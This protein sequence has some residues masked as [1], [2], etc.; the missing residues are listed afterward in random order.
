MLGQK[1]TVVCTQ[2]NTLALAT[3]DGLPAKTDKA[4]LLRKLED[5]TGHENI[6]QLED[7]VNIMDGN[8]LLQAL[9]GLPQTFAELAEKAYCSLPKANTVHF[10]TDTYQEDAIK[11]IE[12]ERWESEAFLMKGQSARLPPERRA[13]RQNNVNK[14]SLNLL[15]HTELKNRSYAKRLQ[16]CEVLFV[17]KDLCVCLSSSDGLAVQCSDVYELC[18]PQEEADTRIILHCL[19]V[20]EHDTTLDII[21][22]SSNTDVIILLLQYGCQIAGKVYLTRYW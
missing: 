7:N 6:M 14:E 13:F 3:P 22:R 21:I 12:R 17:C 16:Y 18:S 1:S 11:S 9:T 4:K 20:T 19:H 10:V 8:A 2:P 15:L 5:D